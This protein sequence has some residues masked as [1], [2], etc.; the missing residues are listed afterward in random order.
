[1]ENLEKLYAKPLPSSRSGAFYN[2]FPYPTKISPETIAVYI[3]CATEPGDTVLD[4]FGG[5]GS[6]GIAA[7]MCEHPTQ[8]M[9][10]IAT[11]LG[12][13]PKWGAR[14]AVLYE[15]GTYASFAAKT[16]MNRITA[17]EYQKAVNEFLEHATKLVADA[18]SVKDPNGNIGVLRYA[19]WSELLIC[20][21][22]GAE[23]SYFAHAMSRNP[24]A[25]AKKI[26]CPY[27]GRTHKTDDMAFSIEDYNDP[28]LKRTISRKKRIPAWVYGS[29]DGKNWDRPACPEDSGSLRCRELFPTHDEPKEIRWGELHRSGYH[30]GITHLHHFYTERNYLVMSALWHLAE[31]FPGCQGDA[32]KLLLLSYNAT[33]CTLMTRVVAKKNASDFILT[34][35]QSG[36]LYVS[37]APVEKNIL[38]GLYRKVKPFAEVYTM[39]ERCTGTMEIH[40][41]SSIQ[42]DEADRSVDF[43]FTDPPFGDFIP[44]AEVNQINELWLGNTTDR[45]DEVI[46]SPSQGKDVSV[47][48]NML[49]ATFHEIDRVLKPNGYVSVVFHAAKAA[50]WDA[51]Y[52]A[53]S[54]VGFRVER[55]SILDK[56]QASFKQVVS[57][58]SVRGDPLFLLHKTASVKA[59]EISDD[60]IL[61]KIMTENKSNQS[62]DMRRCYSMYVYACLEYGIRV[63]KDA[64]Q[65]YERYDQW[66]GRQV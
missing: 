2:A 40:N 61:D 47:Y 9:E 65:V 5:S 7:L 18:Y 14:N 63:A 50:V 19:I 27:C 16:I 29:T 43:V 41:R 10:D 25:F 3:A 26:T 30:Y 35:A 8:R 53:I 38:L 11:S 17:I 22:C 45:A 56:T 46:I 39:L 58:G 51:F 24:A 20:P 54:N 42:M 62:F 66:K 21:D 48:Q 28:I 15:V 59:A 49:M 34:G 6:T 44:Y 23:L 12:V 1:M 60:E 55:S 4:A 32:L 57:E 36:V 52:S 31:T 37:K 33:H 64:K 13:V